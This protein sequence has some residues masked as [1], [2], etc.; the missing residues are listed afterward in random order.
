MTISNLRKWIN[1]TSI[2]HNMTSPADLQI[3]MSPTNF[4]KLRAEMESKY[5]YRPPDKSGKE[6]QKLLKMELDRHTIVSVPYLQTSTTMQT[7]VFILNMNDWELRI[8]SERNFDLTPFVWQGDKTNGYDFWLAR[9][10]ICGNFICWKPNG[11]MWLS[12]VS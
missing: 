4:N 9:I 3:L 7:W 2:A 5:L 8:H 6:T 10:M 12:S 1:E 11:S